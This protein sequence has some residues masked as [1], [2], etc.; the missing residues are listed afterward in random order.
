M[1]DN[2]LERHYEDY[3]KRKS[4]WL[5]KKKNLPFSYNKSDKTKKDKCL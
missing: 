1:A 2:F 4:T 3:E 5:K